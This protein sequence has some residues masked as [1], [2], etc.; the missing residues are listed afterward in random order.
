MAW[1][2]L[3]TKELI[4]EMKKIFIAYADENLA[5][6]LKR[7]GRQARNLGVFDE[8][9][10]YTPAEL[11]DYI[12]K[13]PLMKYKYG[14][15]YWAWKP[16][17][18]YE[19]LQSHEDGDIVVY[20]DAGCTLNKSSEWDLMFK[21]MEEYDTICF[22]Y[23]ANMPVWEKFGNTSTQIKYWTKM[24][25][26]AFLNN[27]FNDK[28]YQ[29]ALKVMGGILFFKKK[30]NNLLKR[31]LDIVLHYPEVI[32][33]PSADE[34]QPV[35]FAKHKHDQSILTALS[36]YDNKTLSLPEIIE[37]NDETSFVCAS[38]IRAKNYE[39]YVWLMIKRRMRSLLGDGI[40]DCIKSRIITH[41]FCF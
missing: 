33:D 16:A 11:P 20:V 8:V 25:S 31:W 30:D 23:D 38:R 24:N 35:G 34:E 9:I 21:L 18:I 17:I 6:S 13:S 28:E 40:I 3:S 39:Q 37:T 29:N 15:G 2:Q 5:Y 36:Y 19:T 10:L 7:I 4:L 1:L 41:S 32:L 22:H 27:Y 12:L 14:G 26:L